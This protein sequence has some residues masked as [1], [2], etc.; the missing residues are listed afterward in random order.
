[1]ELA[2]SLRETWWCLSNIELLIN[3]L[4]ESQKQAEFSFHHQKNINANHKIPYTSTSTQSIIH[5]HGGKPHSISHQTYLTDK[6]MESMIPKTLGAYLH[7]PS[8]LTLWS[9][10]RGKRH[11]PHSFGILP[12]CH[13]KTPLIRTQ[14]ELNK[15]Y[16]SYDAI[17][18]ITSP[19]CSVENRT[20]SEQAT[21]RP[22][23]FPGEGEA[24]SFFAGNLKTT[25]SPE[26]IV[27]P[28]HV[29]KPVI[30]PQLTNHQSS[31]LLSLCRSPT[32]WFELAVT[33]GAGGVGSG[34]ETGG[35]LV[36][37]VA[38]NLGAVWVSKMM[39]MAA[40]TSFLAM[41]RALMMSMSENSEPTMDR[42]VDKW[43][44]LTLLPIGTLT[45]TLTLS[46]WFRA[47]G[48]ENWRRKKKGRRKV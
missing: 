33:V 40:V 31:R 27:L 41:W 19:A 45:L 21:A 37:R 4:K 11:R 13:T 9:R 2:A 32:L 22:N 17:V 46:T 8:I 44:S 38:L 35:G 14:I 3:T 34:G 25:V 47:K 48:L 1:M 29:D 15:R 30:S 28:L 7:C 5:E 12:I 42:T 16:F 43:W 10:T 26:L 6:T 36:G 20:I 18:H 24:E 23:P 39:L